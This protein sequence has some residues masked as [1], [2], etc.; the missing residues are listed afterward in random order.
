MVALNDNCLEGTEKPNYGMGEEIVLDLES[1][2]LS[3]KKEAK[4]SCSSFNESFSSIKEELPIDA[5]D[6][7]SGNNVA[8][9]SNTVTPV[10]FTKRFSK[11]GQ[12]QNVDDVQAAIQNLLGSLETEMSPMVKKLSASPSPKAEAEDVGKVASYFNRIDSRTKLT[13]SANGK[14]RT[15]RRKKKNT[16]TDDLMDK[17]LNL[18]TKESSPRAG[19]RLGATDSKRSIK[20]QTL[21]L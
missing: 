19:K 17:F 4:E 6:E 1:I 18:S 20:N 16:D 5:I 9:A 15:I 8:S 11:I 12:A 7:D 3:S 21:G 2:M 10:S 14:R 13:G